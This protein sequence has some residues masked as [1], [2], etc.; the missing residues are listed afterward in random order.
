VPF[1]DGGIISNTDDMI[2]WVY[3]LHHGKILN[4][5]S[6]AKMMTPYIDS[7]DGVRKIGYGI[8]MIN[9]NGEDIYYHSGKAL[10]ARS[11]T[12]YIPSK[13]IGFSIIS[14]IMP[15]ISQE[16]LS[17]INTTD[18]FSQVDIFFFL[19]DVLQSLKKSND[20]NVIKYSKNS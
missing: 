10:G 6:Y 13:E 8:F 15:L 14:N 20:Q 19:Q 12:G 4:K 16:E 18:S 5:T 9:I 2:T 1:S 3:N 7:P 17:K 11:E